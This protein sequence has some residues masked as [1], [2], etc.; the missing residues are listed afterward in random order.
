MKKTVFWIVSIL[1]ILSLALAACQEQTPE[2]T[3]E[4]MVEEEEVVEE[5]AVV[6]EEEEMVEEEVEEEVVEEEVEEEV[7]EEPVEIGFASVPTANGTTTD[8]KG[9]WFDEVS[10][11]V[12]DSASAVT[13]IE[14]GAIDIYTAGLSTAE[15]FQSVLDAGLA[16]SEAG[17][18]YYELTINPSGD[19][20]FAGTGKLNPFSSAKVR[21]AMNWIIDRDYIDQEVYGGLATPKFTPIYTTLP[22]YAKNIAVMRELEAKYAYD[23][24]KGA[25]VIEEELAAMGAE[26]VEGVWQFNGEPVEVIF[27]I[28]N[29][30][31]GTRIPIGD[32]ISNQL[33]LI[34]LTVDRQYKT[35]PEASPLWIGSDPNDGLWHLYTGAWSATAI[36]TDAGDDVQFFE[37]PQSAYG[38]VPLWQNYF[39]SEEY[40]QKADD[41]T[42]ANYA[43]QEERLQLFAEVLRERFEY[44]YR[45]WIVDGKSFTPRNPGIGTAYDLMAGVDG[46]WIWPHTLRWNDMEGG[47]IKLGTNATFNEPINAIGGSNWAFD[48]AWIRAIGDSTVVLNPYTGIGLPQRIERA[49]VTVQ[50]GKPVYQTYDWVTLEFADE[51]VVPED[52]IVDYDSANQA[53]ITAGEK[54]PEGATAIRKSVAYYPDNLW[55]VTWHDGSNLDMADMMMPWVMTFERANP[56]SPLYDESYAATFESAI[57]PFKGFKILSTDPLVYEYYSDYWTLEAENMVSTLWPG[58]DYGDAAWPIIALSNVGE[59]AGTMAYTADKADALEIERTG[60]AVGP[61]IEIL[62]A[63]LDALIANPVVPFEGVLGEYLTVDDVAARYANLKAFYETYGHFYAGTG[64]VMLSETFPV[65]QTLTLANNPNY[66]DYADKWSLFSEPK[67]A[68]VEIDGAGR[69]TIGEPATFDVFIT[70]GGEDYPLNEIKSVSYLLFG[71]D[72]S[73]VE[74][75]DAVAQSDGYF[76]VELSAESTEM[77]EAGASKLEIAVS[78]IPVALPSLASFEFVAE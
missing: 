8:R 33:E 66:I 13:Q 72:G 40:A 7:V 25:G 11:V 59:A 76:T 37:T 77:L 15:Q 14:A 31:D 20:A 5:E 69:L 60:W 35:S 78:V 34:G 51:I 49:E 53:W 17:G 22:D 67:I 74:T 57:A 54:W 4:V 21:E 28:R 3:E 10:F 61:T 43:D 29:D 32:Y 56:D 23:F 71:A 65:E 39:I 36:D 63:D 1:L 58:Y 2:P 47:L 50:T 46:S 42:N 9:S 68:E 24:D 62:A 6:E 30:S 48:Q 26:K 75:G 41:L 55:D 16:Y 19:P 38:S 18:L 44:S 52:A 73:L 12:V 64:P 45:V 70:S 27:L